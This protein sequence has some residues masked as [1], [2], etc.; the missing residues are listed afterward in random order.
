MTT[1][2]A[3]SAP[4]NFV[5]LAPWIYTPAWSDKISHDIPLPEGISGSLQLT[6]QTHTPLLI[7]EQQHNDQN[8]IKP[9]RLPDGQL[10]IPGSSLRGMIRNVLEIASFGKMQLV[11][12]TRFGVRDLQARF[13]Q[14]QLTKPAGNKQ[15]RPQ[16]KAG[17]L[18]FENNGWKITPCDYA[19]IEQKKARFGTSLQSWHTKAW[20]AINTLNR[21]QADEKYKA[22]RHAGGSLNLAFE[23]D[24]ADYHQHS[25]GNR[26]YYSAV[27]QLGSGSL[28]G[29]LIFTG[30]PGPQKHMEFIFHHENPDNCF[31]VPDSVIKDFL[32][33]YTDSKHWSYLK[34][35][36]PF[37]NGI[38]IFYLTDDKNNISSL[39]LSQMYRLAYKNTVGDLIEKQN[40]S[41]STHDNTDNPDL[42]DLIFGCVDEKQGIN[43]LKGRANFS[44]AVCSDSIDNNQHSQDAILSSPKPTF[45]PNYIIQD[46]NNGQLKGDQFKTYMDNNAQIRG[47]K[48]Y[49]TRPLNLVHV[50]EVDKD[51]R[52]SKAW[53]KL[54]PIQQN[55][56]FCSKLRLHNLHPLELGALIWAL[57]WG[58]QTTLRHSIGMGKPFGYGQLSITIDEQHIDLQA[59][60]PR[61]P[62]KTLS[63]YRNQFVEHM[64]RM[65]DDC[66][67]IPYQSW[68][69]TEQMQQLLAM[70]NPEQAPGQPGS[71]KH[72]QLQHTGKIN[73]F[74][75]TKGAHRHPKLALQNYII[76]QITRNNL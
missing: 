8:E 65:I 36:A 33:I 64:D 74:T 6:I 71:L 11:D 68:L 63:A 75:Q 37:P 52:K 28:N 70:A 53:V 29:A 69:Q 16:S 35:T 46:H 62:L 5:P 30:Q 9:F 45:Y 27:K 15:Y 3:I 61:N 59:N 55:L 50:P 2:E 18:R 73:E 39:G 19:R 4:Y 44:L 26:L 48:R 51:Q 34:N 25:R 72:L 23:A 57:D 31:S 7:G 49:P 21:P 58:N 1:L 67:Y 13:Y 40:K 42:C 14:Q 43:S 41:S 54:F 22:W 56:K 76:K 47:W 60:D 17:W 38:P 20:A 24:P 12:N 32:F 66:D 10:A